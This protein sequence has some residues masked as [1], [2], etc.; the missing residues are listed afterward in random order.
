MNRS[1]SLV[2]FEETRRDE[3]LGLL[4]DAWGEG[5]MT[6]AAF[7]WWFGGNLEGSLLSIAEIDGRAVGV[8]G[9]SLARAIV[10]GRQCLVQF[11]VHATTAEEARGLGIFRALEVRHEEQGTELDSQAVLAFASAPTHPLFL[12]PLGWTQIDRRRVWARALRPVLRRLARKGA[13]AGGLREVA[14]GERANARVQRVERFGE[15][16]DVAYATAAT[17]LRNHLVRDARYLNWRYLDSPKDYRAF[18]TSNGFSVVGHKLHRGVSTAYVAELVAPRGEASELLSRCV[19]EARGGAELVV[20]VP[21]PTLPK[22]LLARAGFVPS[23]VVLDFMGKGLAAPIDA[24]SE[25][26]SVSLGD[27]DF[28]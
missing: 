14:L 9:H 10:G 1:Y 2:A 3:Y 24:R 28:F 11:S 15:A 21:S 4:R 27:T 19:A 16:A 22:A 20:A 5:S 17:S 7:D 18:S 6:A 23:T 13:P 8:A 26:W 12:G 25:A